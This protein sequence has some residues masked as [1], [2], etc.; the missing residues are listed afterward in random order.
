MKLRS[1]FI[2]ILLNKTAHLRAL[3]SCS[4]IAAF[5]F[6]MHVTFPGNLKTRSFRETV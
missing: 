2:Q 5:F 6:Y 4:P 3:H 1:V